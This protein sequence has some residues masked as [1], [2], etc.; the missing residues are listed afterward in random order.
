MPTPFTLLYPTALDSLDSLGRVNDIPQTG[1]DGS[2]SSGAT[3]I[4]AL[5]TSGFESS[6]SIV[7]GN[8][9]I[10]YTGKTSTTFTG[11]LRGRNGTTASAHT[12]GAV[13]TAPILAAHRDVLVE[14]V[15]ALQ[16]KVGIGALPVVK[17]FN[18]RTGDVVLTSAD[19][20]G[21]S[22]AGLVGIGS[23]T[24]GISNTGSTS[25]DADT[26]AN[27]TGVVALRTRNLNRL[28]V[29]NDG[30]IQIHEFS[31]GSGTGSGGML[32][33]ACHGVTAPAGF[34]TQAFAWTNGPPG[35]L[36]YIDQTVGLSYN[37]LG[38]AKIMAD[39]VD[40]S[41]NVESKYRN[42]VRGDPGSFQTEVYYSWRSPDNSIS[43]RPW[44]LNVQHDDGSV[45]HVVQ[46]KVDFFR[47]VVNGG[48]QWGL[49]HDDGSLDLSFL[50]SG[51]IS[52]ANN[53]SAGGGIRWRNAAN[54]NTIAPIYVDN[55][56][57]T[58]LNSATGNIITGGSLRTGNIKT[59]Q[60]ISTADAD[61]TVE[62]NTNQIVFNINGSAKF[63]V[64]PSGLR[65]VSA[66]TFD[67]DNTVDV[68]KTGGTNFRPR[69][70]YVGRDVY[71]AGVL[72]LTDG[73][74]KDVVVGAADSGGVGFKMLR[75]VN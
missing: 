26:D 12:S 44:G 60:I 52:F 62:F 14:A 59:G 17:S 20:N 35:E 4:T 24:G 66:L 41:F 73:S 69:D 72:K 48:G 37:M 15:M 63:A 29:L 75:V 70:V 46:G 43:I 7:I 10:Y 23:G 58:I 40:W 74:V 28:Q 13:I 8:E 42:G 6:G 9:Q 2:I 11:C 36:D 16:S 34:F 32:K 45:N 53:S 71:V 1:L 5:D 30:V 21:L 57:D 22:G 65:M 27:G 51:G 50:T 47:D 49:W 67:A 55:N 19:L 33:L 54:D 18:T 56:D 64:E 68:G 3:T 31:V 38:G 25:I 61:D 39:D